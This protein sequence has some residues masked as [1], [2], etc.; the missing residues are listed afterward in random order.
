MKVKDLI[1]RLEKFDPE[2]NI[3]TDFG[4]SVDFHNNIISEYIRHS[5]IKFKSYNNGKVIYLETKRSK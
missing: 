1:R 4:V 2:A 5:G 3:A